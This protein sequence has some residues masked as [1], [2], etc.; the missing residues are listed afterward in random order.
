VKRNLELSLT[1]IVVLAAMVAGTSGCDTE[2]FCFRCNDAGTTGGNAG[3]GG[4]GGGAGTGGM[5]GDGG[6]IIITSGSGGNGNCMADT[7][8]DPLNCGMCGNVCSLPNAFSVCTGGFCLVDTCAAGFVDLDQQVANGCEYKCTPSNGGVEI[9]DSFDNDCNGQ[10]DELTDLQTDQFNCGACNVVCQFTNATAKCA[11]GMCTLD[12]CLVGYNDVNANPADGCEYACTETNGGVEVCDYAD[13]NCNIAVDEGFDLQTDPANCGAC[14]NACSMLYPNSMGACTAATC[15]FAGC[16]N[17]YYNIDGI[18]ANGCEYACMPTGMETCDGQ[19][20]DCNGLVD[21]GTLPGAGDPCGFSD[22]GECLLG[23]QACQ[24]GAFVCVG[25]IDPATELCDAKDNNCD[26]TTDEGCPSVNA[27]DTRLDL[28]ANSAVGQ[29]T[30][31]QLSVA[32]LNDVIVA[33]YL[34]RRSGNADIRANV[35][36]NGGT[37]WLAADVGV[38]SGALVQVEPAVFLSPTR[39]YV[40]LAQFPNSAHRDV[41]IANAPAPNYNAF[42]VPARVDKVA[43]AADAILIQGVV[44]QAGAMGNQDKLVVV[45]QSLTGTGTNVTTDVFLQRSIDGGATWLAQD[46]R[47]N[48]VIGNAEQPVIASDGNGKAFIAWR[49]SRNGKA[50]VFAATY[51]A[52][53]NTLGTNTPVSGG[54]PAEQITIAANSGGPNVYIAWTD[55]RSTKKTI[56]L[57]RSTNSGTNYS[58]DGTI[59]NTDSTFADASLPALATSGQ[60][61]GVAW[62]DTRSGVPAIRVSV[63]L[64]GGT[65]LP[66]TTA[67]AD[68]GSTAGTSASTRP[69]IAFGAGQKV[70][71]TWE[72]ARNGQR[73]I[74]ANHSFDNGVNFQPLE[75]RMDVGTMGAP[76]PAG[77]ADSRNPFVVTNAA[78]MRGIVVWNDYRT[79]TGA[80]GANGDI[81]ANRFE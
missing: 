2:A 60:Q 58:S 66:M 28:G 71:V 77:I 48:A 23:A 76:S 35:S 51:D 12:Q 16:I 14:G 20:N 47:V 38:A 65:T 40:A 6:G 36:T 43:T 9:C 33:A 26:A 79:S 78:G 17:G 80:N 62:E 73:D 3:A 19:D 30:S 5:G 55:L 50:E 45:W 21:D 57:A 10:V 56:R 18:E 67:R 46:L 74:Y 8:T 64:D 68:L 44:A 27:M 7:M 31:T 1:S 24:A 69:R 70:F 32:N 41:Y 34:D 53:A 72:D 61:V 15:S 81:Y 75:L 42:T 29:A 4:D 59:V 22:V 54:Q 11:A 49:D 63:S 25:N 39:A 37:S 52:T 13:N